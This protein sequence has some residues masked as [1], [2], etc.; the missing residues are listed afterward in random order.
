[1]WWPVDHVEAFSNDLT[2]RTVC[3]RVVVLPPEPIISISV[4]LFTR[5][6]HLNNLVR[7]RVAIAPQIITDTSWALFSKVRSGIYYLLFRQMPPTFKSWAIM[8]SSVKTISR[9]SKSLQASSAR[10]NSTLF[11][12]TS[13][14]RG[15]TGI[16]L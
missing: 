7:N 4:V 11:R 15:G 6:G 2:P 3:G 10:Q 16:V 9:V 14:V 5:R 12:L 1:V 8:F 13:C